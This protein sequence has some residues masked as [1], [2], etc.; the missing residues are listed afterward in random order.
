MHNFKK[1]KIWNDNITLVSETYSLTKTFPDF[2]KFG[3]ASQMNRCAVSIPSNI[4]EGSSKSSGKHFNKYL[5]DSLGS[6]FE[7]ETQLIIAFNAGYLSENTFNQL[8]Q[9]IKQLQKMI[10]SFQSGLDK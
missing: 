10:S 3:L 7:W 8:E 9:N 4:A 6:A 1:L 2:E 5:E